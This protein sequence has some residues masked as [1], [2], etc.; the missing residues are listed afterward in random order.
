MAVV[1]QDP[2]VQTE[3]NHALATIDD[4]RFVVAQVGAG[5][6]RAHHRR[7]T[8]AARQNGGVGQRATVLGHESQH[9][10]MLHQNGVGRGQIVGDDDASLQTAGGQFGVVGVVQIRRVLGHQHALHPPHHML[11]IV[12]AGAQ[13]RVVHVLEYLDQQIPL[14]LQRPFG[15]AL[16]RANQLDR[17]LGE[18]RVFQHQQ[19]GV[20]KGGNLRRRRR[21][22]LDPHIAQ[23]PPGYL[24]TIQKTLD[25]ILDD[26]V[27]DG[28]LGDFR[29][30]ALQQVGSADR[31]P[32]G[33]PDAMQ[34]K[35]HAEALSFALVE[36]AAHQIFEMFERLLGLGTAGAQLQLGA[37]RGRQHHDTHDAFTVDFAPVAQQPDLGVESGRQSHELGGGSGVQ[38]QS[39][40]DDYFP[41]Q[42]LDAPSIPQP[43]QSL[44]G[45]HRQF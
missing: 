5:V 37:T 17:R 40:D 7:N 3:Q 15:I 16:A 9:P 25:F 29:L 31:I 38:P 43:I 44:I 6:A 20:D 11:H 8:Q 12:L 13:I 1:A 19:M 21:R 45:L 24:Q 26:G 30:V 42:H 14:D 28:V 27:G 34:R 41:L 23:L 36:T 2:L 35:R 10:L 39:V 18:S 22:N 4:H 33:N 32:P